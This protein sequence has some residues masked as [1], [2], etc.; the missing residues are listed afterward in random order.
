[1]RATFDDRQMLLPPASPDR[2]PVWLGGLGCGCGALLAAL[3]LLALAVATALGGDL[4][5]SPPD[6][7][8]PDITITIQSAFFQQMIARALPGDILRDVTVKM[9]PEGVV[10]IQGQAQADLLGQQLSMPFSLALHLSAADGRLKV[11]VTDLQVANSQGA[12]AVVQAIVGSLGDQASSVIND[13]ILA[14]LGS[15]AYIMDVSTNERAL[16]IRARWTGR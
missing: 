11:A 10:A 16:V 12:S 15:D 2:T 14:G 9:Q 5:S 1:M 8:R 13:Q 3:A 6:P 7:S 4:A